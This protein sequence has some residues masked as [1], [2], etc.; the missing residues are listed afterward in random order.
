MLLP[1][2]VDFEFRALK[3]ILIGMVGGGCNARCVQKGSKIFMK[4]GDEKEVNY[5]YPLGFVNPKG[6]NYS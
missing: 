1:G 5:V 3:E 4:G 2:L 6:D